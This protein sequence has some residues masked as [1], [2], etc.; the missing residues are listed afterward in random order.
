[1]LVLFDT[2]AGHALFKLKKPDKLQNAED[3]HASFT[4]VDAAG[5]MC[6][7]PLQR[8]TREG[9]PTAAAWPEDR[10]QRR[11]IAR[12]AWRAEGPQ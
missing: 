7:R 10:R 3:L 11:R 6:A 5:K 1:M 2:P 12:E 8:G 4:S 9:W